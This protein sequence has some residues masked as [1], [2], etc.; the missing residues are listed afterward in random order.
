MDFT[1]P[2]YTCLH[3]VEPDPAP[4][5]DGDWILH[6]SECSFCGRRIPKWFRSEYSVDRSQIVETRT[7]ERE[8]EK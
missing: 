8:G 1:D 4:N 5:T 2:I 7:T 3:A 6:W